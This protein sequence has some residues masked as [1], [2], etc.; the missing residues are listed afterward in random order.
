MTNIRAIP[1]HP[2]L[3]PLPI[4]LRL[5][6]PGNGGQRPPSAAPCHS[7]DL[8]FNC[9]RLCQK[10]PGIDSINEQSSLISVNSCNFRARSLCFPPSISR[11]ARNLASL[12]PSLIY[13]FSSHL[14][15]AGAGTLQYIYIYS[16]D[17]HTWR[18]RSSESYTLYIILY[19][20]CYI[21]RSSESCISYIYYMLYIEELWVMYL[22][23]SIY[24]I[25]TYVHP[26]TRFSC[27]SWYTYTY[28]RLGLLYTSS[29]YIYIYIYIW[30]QDF[31]SEI[32]VYIYISLLLVDV[33]HGDVQR[34]RK[35]IMIVRL[36]NVV[37]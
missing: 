29:I 28:I 26:G 21:S 15:V 9:S 1:Y 19:T 30:D 17:I 23:Y 20:I 24:I 14:K 3:I 36:T 16:I 25:Y 32:Y 18:S 31:L 4:E 35:L 6:T 13:L 22:I 34:R 37:S 7:I 10:L 5:P 12:G 8:E 33:C 2:T 27:I 11:N